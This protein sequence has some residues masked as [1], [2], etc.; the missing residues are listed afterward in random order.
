MKFCVK[1][2]TAC[3]MLKHI[4]SRWNKELLSH[5]RVCGKSA[6]TAQMDEPLYTGSYD[7]SKDKAKGYYTL[8]FMCFISNIFLISKK[9]INN[10]N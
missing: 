2:S 10:Q 8:I 3:F 1:Y 6:T 4:S 9:Q 7:S 5:L